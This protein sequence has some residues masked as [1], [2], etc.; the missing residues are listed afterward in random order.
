MKKIVV[1]VV[2]LLVLASIALWVQQ[3]ETTSTMAFEISDFAYEDT[4]SVDRI[5]LTDENGERIVLTREESIWM[6]NDEF[7]ARP[8]AVRNLLTT[9]KKVSIRAPISQQEMNSVL[10]NIIAGHTLVEVHVGNELV[11]HFYVGG[12]DREHTGTYMLMKGSQRPFLTH[13]EG[14]HGFLTP[15]FFMNPLEWRH[16]GIFELSPDKIQRIALNYPAFPGRSFL[17]ERDAAGDFG[18][19]YGDDNTPAS[20]IDSLMLSAYVRNY[21]M[22]HY[23]SHEETKTESFLD[24]VKVSDPIFNISVTTTDGATKE[25]VGFR[26]PLKEGYDPEGNEID[27]DLDRLYIWVDSGEIFIGQYAIFDKLTKGISFFKS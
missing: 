14:F 7:Q 16:R 4:A 18:V 24:S 27:Y 10:K 19:F 6:L 5:V 23:E 3:R 9:I 8:D 13:I 15:R 21:E 20:S 26:K 1:G 2:F 11:K 17:I 22:I 25:V 12:P